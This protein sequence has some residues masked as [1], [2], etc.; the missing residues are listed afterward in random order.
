MTYNDFNT[1]PISELVKIK[2]I[3]AVTAKRIVDSRN[4][5]PFGSVSDLLKVRGIGQK[6]LEKMGIS[7]DASQATSAQKTV[8]LT[9]GYAMDAKTGT[10]DYFWNIPTENRM[11]FYDPARFLKLGVEDLG[12]VIFVH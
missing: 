3:G 11:Y 8:D 5:S 6:T 2:G 9:A 1:L 4:L 10:V 12:N 7:S